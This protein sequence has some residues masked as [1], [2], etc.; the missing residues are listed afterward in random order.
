MTTAF[1]PEPP[2]TAP[3]DHAEVPACVL[4]LRPGRTVVR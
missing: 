3:V 1:R 2:R 4:V